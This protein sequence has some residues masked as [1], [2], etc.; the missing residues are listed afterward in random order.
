ME[1]NKLSNL[2]GDPAPPSW[3]LKLDHVQ[4]WAWMTNAF[5]D[6]ECQTIIDLGNSLNKK[7]AVINGSVVDKEWR[8]SKVAWFQPHSELSWLY[9]RMTDIVNTLNDHHFKFDLFGF[10][11]PFQFTEYVAPGGKYDTHMDKSPLG[12]LRKLSLVVQLSDESDYKGGELEINR[13]EPNFMLKSRGTVL[14][15]P[16][17]MMHKVHPV[18]EGTRYS[19]VSWVSGPAFK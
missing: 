18:T 7:Q 17:Y 1:I 9:A 16:S 19:L 3:T 13:G 10:T 12:V 5:S 4:D 15:F 8:D 6:S 11:E 14:A 2:T